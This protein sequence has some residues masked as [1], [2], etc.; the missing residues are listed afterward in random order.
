MK[1]W[2]RILCA[3]L[4]AALIC[5]MPFYLSAPMMIQEAKDTLLNED[6]EEDE[7][8]EASLSLIMCCRVTS[9]AMT[10]SSYSV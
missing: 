8:D 9:I 6:E 7:D 4:C 5:G 1:T 10:Y 2:L 3:L